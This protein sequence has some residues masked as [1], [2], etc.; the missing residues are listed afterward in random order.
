LT[1]RR[2]GRARR[3]FMA[4]ASAG[5]LASSALGLVFILIERL[6]LPIRQ[7]GIL[8]IVTLTS[9]AIG[10]GASWFALVLRKL[11]RR[12]RVFVSYQQEEAKT[13]QV[14]AKRLR[15]H[16]AVVW[17]DQE[18]LRPGEDWQRAIEAAVRDSDAFV[19]LI[20]H[21]IT[22]SFHSELLL[23]QRAGVTI[24]PVLVEAESHIPEE[25][26]SLH[27]V[28]MTSDPTSAL[29]Q[30]VESATGESSHYR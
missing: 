21:E 18:R 10:A 26:R 25:V 9:F 13:A 6:K 20:P 12:P 5:G 17:L 11:Q 3:N 4:W 28:D 7:L 22:P 29:D 8:A 1:R 15:E 2:A 27:F 24:L 30:L 19:M 16:G 23:A 14:I